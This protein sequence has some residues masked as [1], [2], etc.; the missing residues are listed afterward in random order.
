MKARR[1]AASILSVVVAVTVL[2]GCTA[3][4]LQSQY[5]NGDN[6]GY[7]S[8]TGVTE[9][10]PADRKDPVSFSGTTDQGTSF[11]TADHA[12]DVIVVNFWYAGCPPCRL[13]AKSL[14]KLNVQFEGKGVDFVGVN[15]RDDKASAASY[16]KTFGVTYPS[17]LDASKGRV[18]LAFSGTYRPN[19]TPTT[20]I[21]DKQGRVAARIEGPVN[22][23]PSTVST[24][25]DAARGE[26][27]PSAEGAAVPGKARHA[28]TAEGGS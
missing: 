21:L 25:I 26:R 2:S 24:L 23:Q 16:D 1:L 17:I 10:K 11:S 9:I 13:E 19:A 5:E 8:G 14:Q 15:T 3:T 27:A 20:I 28:S 4:A 6:K 18:Q 12:G 7:I 22:D